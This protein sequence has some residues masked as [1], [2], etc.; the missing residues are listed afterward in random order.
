MTTKKFELTDIDRVG[1]FNRQYKNIGVNLNDY[2][3]NTL[4]K[5]LDGI[6]DYFSN[7]DSSVSSLIIKTNFTDRSNRTRK[8]SSPGSWSFR[9]SVV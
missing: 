7:D 8:I 6:I 9:I 2:V 5:R 4:P 1:K 3:V